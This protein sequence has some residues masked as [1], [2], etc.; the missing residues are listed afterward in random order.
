M[1]YRSAIPV[2]V[3]CL[4][5]TN[6]LAADLMQTYMEALANDPA[7]RQRKSIIDGRSGKST[8]GLAKL[9]TQSLSLRRL[10]TELVRRAEL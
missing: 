6:V 8:Q 5:A 2:L 1:H 7:I 3:G 9:I 10:W 4:F